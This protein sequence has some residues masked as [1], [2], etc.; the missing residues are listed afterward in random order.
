MEISLV[1]HFWIPRQESCGLF[2]HCFICLT[3]ISLRYFLDTITKPIDLEELRNRIV[4][5]ADF[6][7]PETK[8]NV[9]DNFY[10]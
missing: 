8:R 7:T 1:L 5:Q 6:I 4:C 2:I 9:L 10:L 3:V